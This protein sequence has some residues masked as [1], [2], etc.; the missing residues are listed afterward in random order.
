MKEID[1]FVQIKSNNLKPTRGRLLISEPF[2]GDFF[3]GRSVVLLTEHNEEGSFGLILNKPAETT[4]NQLIKDSPDFHSPIFYGGPVETDSLFYVHTVGNEIEGAIQVTNKLW[5]GGDFDI[6][7]GK[8]ELNLIKPNQIRFFMGYS[9]WG[10]DQLN[11]EIKRNSWLIT[12]IPNVNILTT[13]PE[14]L[15]KNMLTRMGKKYS[16]WTKFPVDP[17]AN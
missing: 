14:N 9:G 13:N 15:W 11:S 5:W 8:M 3:F 2:M 7:R 12:N 10:I 17:T 4:F 16:Y 6:L 1:R